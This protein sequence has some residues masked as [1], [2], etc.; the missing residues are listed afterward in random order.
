MAHGRARDERKER[1]QDVLTRLPTTPAGQLG[2]LPPDH[3]QA[4]RRAEATPPA[5]P[6]TDG[7]VPATTAAS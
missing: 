5:V 7:A 6:A 2:D 3:W 1:L 4:T